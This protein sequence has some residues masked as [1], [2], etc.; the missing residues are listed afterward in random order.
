VEAVVTGA[1]REKLARQV[2]AGSPS[3]SAVRS[4]TPTPSAASKCS[5]VAASSGRGNAPEV[6]EEKCTVIEITRAGD[7]GADVGLAGF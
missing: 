5:L 7:A 3:A 6:F 4:A 1:E 2:E